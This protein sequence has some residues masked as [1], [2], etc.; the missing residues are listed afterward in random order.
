[1]TNKNDKN[2]TAE[3]ILKSLGK[4]F[5]EKYNGYIFESPSTAPD[6]L[7]GNFDFT[8]ILREL[9][10]EEIETFFNDYVETKES[11][12]EEDATVIGDDFEDVF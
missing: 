3:Q 12:V 6:Q 9:Q 2:I 5:T 7:D 11:N 1:M 10:P 8:E 4:A